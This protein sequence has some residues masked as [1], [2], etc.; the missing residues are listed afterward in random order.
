MDD[1]VEILVRRDNIS[2]EEANAAIDDCI[3]EIYEAI[4]EGCSLMDLEEIVKVNLGLE[5]D[6]LDEI[7]CML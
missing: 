6:Y 2:Y 4:D 5:P 7:L 3:N 1:I